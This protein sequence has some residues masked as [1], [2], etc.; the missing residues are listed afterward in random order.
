MFEII[1]Q[2][3]LK[4]FY[5]YIGQ[6][7][8]YAMVAFFLTFLIGGCYARKCGKGHFFCAWVLG[9]SILVALLVLYLYT[10]IG[11]TL[12]SRIGQTVTNVNLRPFSTFNKT[13]VERKF[14]YEN[15]LLFVPFGILL[16][17]LAKPFREAW[18]VLLAGVFC[19]LAIE[20]AQLITKLGSFIVD[21]I[22]TNTVG[23]LAGYLVCLGI[24]WG[25]KK[26]RHFTKT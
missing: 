15:L 4:F 9:K 2:D 24:T 17:L 23:M 13:L 25:I 19:S 22:L 5:M 20:V 12:L 3:I 21:D 6:G 16:Y 26:M 8:K 18:A 10:V 1:K 11:I 7:S 14:V